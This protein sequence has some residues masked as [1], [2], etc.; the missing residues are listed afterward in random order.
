MSD[1]K[2]TLKPTFEGAL[3]DIR[4]LASIALKSG[5]QTRM[6]RDLEMILTITE[7]ALM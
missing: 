7:E 2:R 1:T 3:V 6:K 5:D 4:T